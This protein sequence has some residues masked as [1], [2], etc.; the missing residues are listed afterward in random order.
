MGRTRPQTGVKCEMRSAKF[1][2][3]NAQFPNVCFAIGI[4]H[5]AFRISFLL[6]PQFPHESF[7]ELAALLVVLNTPKLGDAGE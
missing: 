3:R 5:F 6:L 7:E 1:E 2:I 4:S